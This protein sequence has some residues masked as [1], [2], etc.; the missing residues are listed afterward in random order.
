LEALSRLSDKILRGDDD[1]TTEKPTTGVLESGI[2]T[3]PAPVWPAVGWPPEARSL[4]SPLS[5]Q[6]V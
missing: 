6:R 5:F 2:S 3:A 4:Y 1:L